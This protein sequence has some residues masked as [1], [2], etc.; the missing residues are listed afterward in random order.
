M[1]KGSAMIYLSACACLSESVCE[2]DRERHTHTHTQIRCKY[3][4]MLRFEEAGLVG[5]CILHLCYCLCLYKRNVPLRD[6]G[7]EHGAH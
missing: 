4:K 5:T 6:T 1:M 7:G 3:S 2:R